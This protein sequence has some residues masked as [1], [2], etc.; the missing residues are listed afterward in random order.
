MPNA[1][2]IG[3]DENSNH[4][5]PIALPGPAVATYPRPGRPDQLP[6]LSPVHGLHRGP[7]ALSGPGFDLH[8]RH[9]AV[10][11]GDEVH[12]TVAIAEASLEDA[13]AF[14]LQPP[15]RDALTLYA[16]CLVVHR[17]APTIAAPFGECG[18]ENARPSSF[19]R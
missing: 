8:E 1:N 18:T 15:F 6:L 16:E 4:V 2:V 5:K 12:V 10:A 13:P 11:L 19:S 3:R 14:A 17:H 9:E 7:K